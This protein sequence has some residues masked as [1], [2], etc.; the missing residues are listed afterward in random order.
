MDMKF[1]MLPANT[2]YDVGGLLPQLKC[3]PSIVCF[4][5]RSTVREED[6]FT[7]YSPRNPRVSRERA[8]HETSTHRLPCC[9]IGTIDC[10]KSVL[11]RYDEVRLEKVCIGR[12]D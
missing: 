5:L 10:S 12:N 2:R 1:S 6:V 11:P 7:S 4:D 9:S 8:R 3:N